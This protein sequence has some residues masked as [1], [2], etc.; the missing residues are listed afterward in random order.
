[1]LR[2]GRKNLEE[3]PERERE[4]RERANEQRHLMPEASVKRPI[5]DSFPQAR[6]KG[7]AP[8]DRRAL[9]WVRKC[10]PGTST[11]RAIRASEDRWR[12]EGWAEAAW[13]GGKR[14]H[15]RATLRC[16]SAEP[17]YVIFLDN[18]WWGQP[19]RSWKLP[20]IRLV[21]KLPGADPKAS[22]EGGEAEA[23][24]EPLLPGKNPPFCSYFSTPT[25]PTKAGTGGGLAF[26]STVHL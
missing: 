11:A 9:C 23:S 13:D 25:L 18:S 20:T 17:S 21:C 4:R 3:M 7:R 1:M 10:P 19:E 24:L 26:Y 16:G 2:A 14:S 12:A 5:V 15:W 6:A 22:P 8:Q